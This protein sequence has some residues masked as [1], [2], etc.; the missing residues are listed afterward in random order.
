MNLTE[1][2]PFNLPS[3]MDRLSETLLFFESVSPD[4]YE[5][6]CTFIMRSFN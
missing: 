6:T 4:C 2:V 3:G 5:N 1:Y